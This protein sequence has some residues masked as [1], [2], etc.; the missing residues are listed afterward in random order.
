MVTDSAVLRERL[1]H[2]AAEGRA[3]T[4]LW[5]YATYH[6]NLACTYCLTESSPRIADRR[7]L[8]AERMLA[9]ADE[10]RALGFESIGVTG[11]EVFML[12]SFPETLATLARALPT[13]ALTNGMLFTP[14]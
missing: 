2:A 14:A 4:R 7:E 11:G 3:G 9:A 8:A 1:V 12:R 5:L 6:C 13:L 10:A